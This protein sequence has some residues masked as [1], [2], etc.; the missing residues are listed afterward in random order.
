MGIVFKF[1]TTNRKFRVLHAF[2]GDDGA[3]PSGPVIRDGSGNLYGA[4]SEGGANN[5]GT[6]FRVDAAG[7]ETVLYSF[8]GVPD[9]RSPNAPL[10]ADADG[11]LYGTTL[12]GGDADGG[13]VFKLDPNGVE[14]VLYS[15]KGFP[16][17]GAGPQTGLT[18]GKDGNLYGTAVSGGP[19]GWGIVFMLDDQNNEHILHS[20]AG[21]E[22]GGSPG[23]VLVEDAFG[24]FYGKAAR[25]SVRRFGNIFMVD[26]TGRFR[27]IHHFTGPD[28]EGPAGGVILDSQ[29]NLFAMT[30][31][32]GAENFGT[33]FQIHL[34]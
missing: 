9:G 32:G 24:N 28:G 11:V 20:F 31:R 5:Q 33:I 26:A 4:T 14:T 29:R 22:D 2:T 8:A 15:F 7:N 1:D 3:R 19:S 25:E 27:V 13:T 30:T 21:R 10:L 18:R 12:Q 17:D 23:G 16:S 6:I 34:D